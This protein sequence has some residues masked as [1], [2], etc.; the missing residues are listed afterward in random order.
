MVLSFDN[1]TGHMSTMVVSDDLGVSLV[2]SAPVT[3]SDERRSVVSLPL[4]GYWSFTSALAL[5]DVDTDRVE[6]YGARNRELGFR[7]HGLPTYR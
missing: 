4:D 6:L 2:K 5:V 7:N 3:V 1:G